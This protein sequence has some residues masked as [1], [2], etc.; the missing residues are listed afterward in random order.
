MDARHIAMTIYDTSGLVPS[1]PGRPG[2]YRFRETIVTPFLTVF[3]IE[4]GACGTRPF[5]TQQLRDNLK[6]VSRIDKGEQV[7]VDIHRGRIVVQIPLPVSERG[8]RVYT[9]NSVPRGRH[10]RVSLGLDITNHPVYFD[11]AGEMNSSLAFL[12]SAGSGKGV[13]M[14][15]SIAAIAGQNGPDNVKMLMLEVSKQSIDLLVFQNL[16]HLI[17]PVIEDLDEA[18]SALGWAAAQ[19]RRGTLP[20]KLFICVDELGELVTQ[21]PETIP[22]LQ[23]LVSQGRAL[24]I[25]NL[26]ATQVADKATIGEGTKVFRQVHNRVLGKVSNKQLSYLL[27]N[28]SGLHAE[29]LTGKG[30]LIMSTTEFTTRFAGVMNSP[31]DFESLP[32]AESIPRLPIGEYTNTAAIAEDTYRSPG[33]DQQVIPADVVAEGLISLQRQMDDPQYRKQMSGKKYF[34]MPVSKVKAMGRNPAIFR[35]RD[36]PQ[37]VR[38]YKTLLK[39]GWQLCAGKEEGC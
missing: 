3:Q 39:R 16:P 6:A 13:S 11:F 4:P 38:I 18:E 22:L 8:R 23:T 34:V 1:L 14:Q 5:L 24:G 33:P 17:H 32:R 7:E 29:S 20:F 12:G 25:R 27:G 15:R 31:A 21:R 36:Q 26:L 10:L 2:N 30:D 35:D 9:S 19:T 37:L 28:A